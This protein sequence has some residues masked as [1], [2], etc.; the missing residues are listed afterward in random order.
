MI[1]KL[2]YP[3]VGAKHKK[4]IHNHSHILP[5]FTIGASINPFSVRSSGA[6]LSSGPQVLAMFI[7]EYAV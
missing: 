3:V 6:S 5:S 7:G 2:I 4:H 1:F